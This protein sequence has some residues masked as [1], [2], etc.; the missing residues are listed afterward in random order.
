MI[1]TLALLALLALLMLP[2]VPAGAQDGE[3]PAGDADPRPTILIV[4]MEHLLTESAAARSI[5]LQM[6]R[7]RAALREKTRAAETAIREAE[8]TLAAAKADMDPETFRARVAEFETSVEAARRDAQ[9]RARR[10][11]G[12]QTT[13]VERLRATLTPILVAVMREREAAVMLDES[14]VLLSASGLDVTAEVMDR[15]DAAARAIRVVAP[16][17]A[18]PGPASATEDMTDEP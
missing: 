5:A 18:M 17:A 12:A 13:A 15:L 16:D 4:K 11:Q 2:P 3:A 6:E 8:R 10:L 1:R 14:Q 7:L 9:A